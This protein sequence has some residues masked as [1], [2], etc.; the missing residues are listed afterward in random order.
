MDNKEL[1]SYLSKR[2]DYY[3]RLQE[4]EESKI[5]Y[6]PALRIEYMSKKQAYQEIIE[7][8]KFGY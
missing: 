1:I 3:R 8:V 4:E 5:N 2:R 7:H 6:N